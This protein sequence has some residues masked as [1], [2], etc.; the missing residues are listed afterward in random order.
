MLRFPT[1]IPIRPAEFDEFKEAILSQRL[2]QSQAQSTTTHPSNV[3]QSLVDRER[4]QVQERQNKSK[5]QRI[6]LGN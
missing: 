6:G 5:S 1:T 3:D 2:S 4:V